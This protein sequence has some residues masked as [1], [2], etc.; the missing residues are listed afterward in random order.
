MEIISMGLLTLVLLS[1]SSVHV[2]WGFGGVWPGKDPQSLARTVVGGPVGMSPPPAWACFG[3]ALALAL[4]AGMVLAFVGV[5][6]LPLPTGWLRWGM[7]ALAVVFLLGGVGGTL[8]NGCGPVRR[9]VRSCGS[10][11]KSTRRCVLS[12]DCWRGHW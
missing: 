5:L 10:T 7:G 2:Y 6:T 4:A 1:I 11:N 8:W 12:W 9:E 3:V